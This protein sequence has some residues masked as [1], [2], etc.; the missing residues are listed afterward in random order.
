MHPVF[1]LEPK[2][3]VI[4]L[5]RKKWSTGPGTPLALK[6]SSVLLV[7]PGLRTGPGMGLWAICR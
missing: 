7:G 2:Y 3:R 5:T 6:C 4:I 1:K